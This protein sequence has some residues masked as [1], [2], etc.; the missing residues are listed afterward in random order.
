KT[1]LAI[2]VAAELLAHF[3]DGVWFV[4]LSRLSDPSLVLP[5]ITQTLGIT[6]T[7]GQL[8]AEILQAALRAQRLLLVLDNF[9]QVVGAA[10]EVGA[11]LEECPHVQVLVT[12]RI[13]L[14]LRGEREY[15]LAPLP[16][17]DPGH[18]PLPERLAQYAAV[19]LFVERAQ[20][21]RPDFA[22][23]AAN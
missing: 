8:L 3:P 23:T 2:Q 21:A 17:P 7:G 14:H 20:A 10:P 12:S 1:R 19:A 22:V 15:P 18:L 9:E 11:L 4:R 5:A 13:V 6:E 16:L